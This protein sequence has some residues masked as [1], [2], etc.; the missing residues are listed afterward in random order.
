MGDTNLIF[1]LARRNVRRYWRRGLQCFLVLFAGAACVML[2]DSFMRGFKTQAAARVVAQS[3]LAD[4][5]GPGY[6]ESMDAF[7]LDLAIDGADD[8]MGR[9]RA[10]AAGKGD[11]SAAVLTA[12]GIAT[13][14]LL[15]NGQD[16]VPLTLA[17]IQP[18]AESSGGARPV[19]P[20]AWRA[21]RSMKR[22]RYFDSP[23]EAGAI[24]DQ[25]RA[26]RL[27][28]GPGDTA[29]LLCTDATGS[30]AMFEAPILGIAPTDSLPMEAGCVVDLGSAAAALDMAGKATAISLWLAEEG[31][32]GPK[33]LGPDAEPEAIAAAIGA[34]EGAGLEARPFAEISASSI[35][36]FRFL[37]A[38]ILCMLG[39]FVVV[40]GAGITNT[41]LLSVQDRVRDMGTL[42]AIALT[43]RGTG[44]LVA[45]ETL[46][47]GL[48]A[49]FA[50]FLVSSPVIIAIERIGLG[51]VFEYASISKD[52]PPDIRPVYEPARTAL[53][54]LT[55]V[56]VSLAA[57]AMPIRKAMRLTVR[58]SCMET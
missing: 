45:S 11:L 31:R 24:I 46:I 54:G 34:A 52:F 12:A 8:V 6:V 10:A 28:L 15:S 50:A 51:I 32:D 35:A 48:A 26:D 53:I 36:L 39:V 9:M 14:A 16:S 21:A 55:S 18:F 30:F 43:S 20:A 27:K 2:I 58:E 57:A 25:K 13:G 42:R 1:F 7:P 40:A 29:I 38:F 37:D 19:N 33:L 22:G 5:H 47:I 3:G 44:L 56:V 41:I 17:C 49:S 4:A 23:G